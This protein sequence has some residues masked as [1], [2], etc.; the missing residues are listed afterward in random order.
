[1]IKYSGATWT[2]N[3]NPKIVKSVINIVPNQ[4]RADSDHVILSVVANFGELLQADMNA[5]SR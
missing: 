1:M 5:D 4:A 3:P 2:N